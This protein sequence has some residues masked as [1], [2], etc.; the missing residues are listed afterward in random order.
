MDALFSCVLSTNSAPELQNATKQWEPGPSEFWNAGCT[1]LSVLGYCLELLFQ[2][3]ARHSSVN[4]IS[5]Q[6]L[7]P[8]LVS[9]ADGLAFW[10][11]WQVRSLQNEITSRYSRALQRAKADRPWI[12]PVANH[13]WSS[14]LR[15]LVP[16]A[17]VLVV[18]EKTVKHIW[19]CSRFC[20]HQIRTSNIWR[21]GGWGQS[22]ANLLQRFAKWYWYDDYDGSF[23]VLQNHPTYCILHV[24]LPSGTKPQGAEKLP[25]K[26]LTTARSRMNLSMQSLANDCWMLLM[27][28]DLGHF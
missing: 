3:K 22:I 28:Q 14:L 16:C 6:L 7:K 4:S 10:K 8:S 18:F 23:F 20:T 1:P 19:I 13:N 26:A 24:R 2:W 12:S 25:N 9:S 5:N 21:Y 15:S 11:L 27:G 17:N